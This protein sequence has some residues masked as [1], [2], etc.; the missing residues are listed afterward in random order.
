MTSSTFGPRAATSPGEEHL[1]QI[2]KA[3]MGEGPSFSVLEIGLPDQVA[4]V[5][6]DTAFWSVVPVADLPEALTGQLLSQFE[7]HKHNF[8]QEMHNLRFGLN[9]SAVYFNPTERCNFNCSYCYLPEEMRRQGRS[10]DAKEVCF[11][12]EKF[13]DYFANTLPK[14]I[15]PQIIFHGS[16]PM[17]AK[18]AVFAGIEHFEDH[19]LFG[20]QTNATLLDE[21]SLEF[22]QEH[23]VGIGISLDA[24]RAEVADLTRKN[25][26]GQGAFAKV[27]QVIE[28]LSDYPAYNVITTVTKHNY[29]YLTELVDFYHQLQV[30]VVMFNPVRC[31]RQGGR[32]V[33]PEDQPFL[34]A[35]C[36]ALDRC[37]ELY[38]QSGQKLVVANFANILASI[39]GPTGRRLM[40]DI[41]PCGGGRCFFALSAQGEGFP[42]SEFIGIPGFKGGN[43]KE[44]SV[45]EIMA[46]EP[47]VQMR[48]RLVEEIEPCSRC[49]IR[50]YCGAPCPAE[51]Y[52]LNGSLKTPAPFCEF[53]QGQV[54][55]AF[56]LIAQGREEAYLWDDWAEETIESFSLVG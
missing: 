28:Q 43:L 5:E 18:E 3:N 45:E 25:W 32:E 52:K 10:M 53:Y 51:V 23:Q 6:P 56:R 48:S 35:F 31:T 41:T 12:L 34:Q 29:Q 2:L 46:C 17:L 9:L 38:Q 21:Q 20:V 33:K 39:L 30:P 44:Q 36:Q 54:Q 24:P 7:F 16:E 26:Q 4:V 22:L 1:K 14:G 11:Y 55:Y 37:Y 50:H 19:F 49:A 13:A 42:C 8:A 27:V 40:C 47:F 15:K